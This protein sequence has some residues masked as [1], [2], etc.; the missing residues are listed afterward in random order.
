MMRNSQS[1]PDGQHIL[2]ICGPSGSGKTTLIRRLLMAV[3]RLRFTVSHTTRS[4][5][6]GETPGVDYHFVNHAE[7]Q[8]MIEAGAFVEWAD[9]HGERYGT[10]WSELKQPDRNDRTMILD[11]D[12]QGAESVRKLMP[13]SISV[14][15]MPPSLHELRRRLMDRESHWTRSLEARLETARREMSLHHSFDFIVINDVLDN[16]LDALIHIVCAMELRT[17]RQLQRVRQILGEQE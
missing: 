2:I 9:V 16:A 8:A 15:I 3:P 1:R 4:R 12:V 11:V 5:R 7:F 13:A 6:P 17:Q 14:F 10:G